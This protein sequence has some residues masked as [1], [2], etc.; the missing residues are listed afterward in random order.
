MIGH[1]DYGMH[2]PAQGAAAD[3]YRWADNWVVG[4]SLTDERLRLAELDRHVVRAVVEG[5]TDG[6]GE[7]LANY[8]ALRQDF[9]KSSLIRQLPQ[10]RIPKPQRFSAK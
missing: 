10:L 7:A 6:L 1:P 5:D 9:R 8:M 4:I 3:T 2:R